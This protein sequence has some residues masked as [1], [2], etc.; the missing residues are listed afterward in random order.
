V[1]NYFAQEPPASVSSWVLTRDADDD[2]LACQGTVEGR[3]LWEFAAAVDQL[4]ASPVAAARV[5]PGVDDWPAQ[6]QAVV[7]S[8]VRPPTGQTRRLQALRPSVQLWRRTT[9]TGSF[10]G[11]DGRP[12]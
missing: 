3:D 10:G 7:L 11:L 2:A 1:R 5:D 9:L 8:T 6:A 12:G 4:V